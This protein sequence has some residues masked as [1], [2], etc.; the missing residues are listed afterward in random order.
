ML[1]RQIGH[2]R[3]LETLGSG[4]MGEVYRAED[5]LLHRV[6]ALK[7]LAPERASQ[8]HS[9]LRFQREARSVAALNHPN[10]VTIYSVEESDGLHFLTMELVEGKTLAEIIPPEGMSLRGLL[11]VAVPLAEALD[12]AH[13][14]GIV[15]RD[16]KPENVMVG[17]EGRVKVLDF[18]IAKETHDQ[19]ATL[20]EGEAAREERLT[21]TGL[22]L[23]T[24]AYMAP[25]QILSRPVDHRAD[26][27]A[28][29]VILYEMATGRHP[30]RGRGASE[31]LAAVLRDAPA[32]PSSLN[33]MAPAELDA[34]VASCLEKDA[35][36]RIRSA[37]ALRERLQELAAGLSMGSS[38]SRSTAAPRRLVSPAKQPRWQRQALLLA[39]AGCLVLAV[40]VGWVRFSLAPGVYADQGAT[41][42]GAANAE[43]RPGLA[44]LP[45]GN[46]SNDPEYF[47]DGMTDCLISSLSEVRGVRV[48]SRQSVMRYKGSA[49]SLPRIAKELGVNLVVQGSVLRAGNRV[50]ITAQLIRAAPEQ[51]LWSRSYERDLR[52]VLSLQ[53]EVA[54]AITQEIKVELEPDDRKRLASGRLVDPAAYDAYLR[55]RHAWNR[56]TN[57]S[58]SQ[59]V[60]SFQEAVGHDAGFALAHAGLADAYAWAGSHEALPPAETFQ[61][62]RRHAKAALAIDPKLAD[63][64]TSLGLVQ[65]LA[66]RD[67]NGAEASFRRAL[68]LQ[69]NHPTAHYFYWLHLSLRG[70]YEEAREQIGLAA[71]LDPLSPVITLN[72]GLEATRA[73]QDQEAL[74]LWKKVQAWDPDQPGTDLYFSVFYLRKGDLELSRRHLRRSLAL[75]YAEIAAPMDRAA[76][77]GGDHAAL[78]AAAAAL[79]GLSKQGKVPPDDVARVYLVLGQRDQ[80]L[81][82]LE[83]AYEQGSPWVVF[84]RA[85]MSWQSLHGEPR[86]KALLQ[87]IG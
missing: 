65:L 57:E 68:A 70:R 47:V 53:N 21:R 40:T 69:P 39:F 13:G 84:F 64:Y 60:R 7:V 79:E 77:T 23:G 52:D 56:R 19:E 58:M 27:F 18:G 80:A 8:P 22:V 85:D 63:A 48:I 37:A 73:G 87:K 4:G 24:P 59:A 72:L 81:D 25:E 30:F 12:A 76:Q 62:A 42:F 82:W 6:V 78:A 86:F 17:R 83:R 75:Q 50:R 38:A 5:H 9:L 33:P 15:H 35:S 45:L 3:L 16:L 31:T 11:D 28:F 66:D 49:R 14:R 43:Q 2:Y 51:Q 67:W 34:L 71:Q 29:G 32:P 54:R 55:G 26:L 41:A 36:R 61:Q 44:V 20:V 46:F 1:D 10:I 74:S